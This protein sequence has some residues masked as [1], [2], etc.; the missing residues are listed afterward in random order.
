MQGKATAN[1]MKTDN[2]FKENFIILILCLIALVGITYFAWVFM[3]KASGLVIDNAY[4][5]STLI[6]P[7]KQTVEQT[8]TNGTTKSMCDNAG[9]Q[10]TANPQNLDGLQHIKVMNSDGVYRT[11]P[12]YDSHPSGLV[13]Y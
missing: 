12:T 13:Q 6:T 5:A 7:E 4:K 11:V 9:L 2:D 10:C 8:Y 3:N 1:E